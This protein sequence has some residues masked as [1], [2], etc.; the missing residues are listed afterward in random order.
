MKTTLETREGE[1]YTRNECNFRAKVGDQPRLTMWSSGVDFSYTDDFG[2]SFREVSARFTRFEC[3]SFLARFECSSFFTRFECSSSNLFEC[4]SFFTRFECSSFLTRF[5][6][7][8]VIFSF[9]VI[10]QG[11]KFLVSNG[12]VFVAQL[13]D[14]DKQTVNLM[15]HPHSFRV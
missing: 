7:S 12:F 10:S 3:S 15:V 11:N 14:K 4:I 5:G 13:A 8:P 1:N 2:S 9:Q 6:C